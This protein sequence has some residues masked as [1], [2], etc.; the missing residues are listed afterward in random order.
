MPGR[1]AVFVLG[2]DACG[3]VLQNGDKAFVNG[4]ESSSGRSSTAA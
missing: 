2:P 1:K 3:A 4:W